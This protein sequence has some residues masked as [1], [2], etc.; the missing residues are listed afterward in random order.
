MQQIIFHAIVFFC[1]RKEMGKGVVKTRN[2][3]QHL[4]LAP[5]PSLIQVGA[6][7]WMCRKA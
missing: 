4:L 5:Q 2:D 6:A 1:A 7:P 3:I